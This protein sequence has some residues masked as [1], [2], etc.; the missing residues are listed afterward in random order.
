MSHLIETMAFMGETPWHELGNVLPPKQP[1]EVWA[2]RAGMDWSIRET[3]VC[4]RTNGIDRD[5]AVL[6]FEDRKVLYRSDTGAALSVVGNRYEVVQPRDVLEFYRD[7]TT[8]FGF[9]LETAGVLKGGRK[10]WALARTGQDAVLKGRDAVANFLLLATSC[11]GSLATV[12]MPTSVRVVCQN[13]LSAAI[14]GA[15]NAIKVPHSRKFDPAA[16]KR[17]L[18]I[19]TSQWAMFL[20]R[21]QAM[22]NRRV[23]T[24]EASAYFERVLGLVAGGDAPALPAHGRALKRMH[25]LFDGQGRG[26]ELASAKGTT[27]GLLNAVTEFVDHERRARS[28]AHRLDSAWFGQGASLKQQAFDLAVDMVR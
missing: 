14:Q 18:G 4:Y 22:A 10:L 24:V 9:E 27:W 2:K 7:L 8:A 15:H 12:A 21:I 11:D 23:K 5:H 6:D 16:V 13:T 3:P 20:D 19:A 1:V 28:R 25:D 17:Q 26:A